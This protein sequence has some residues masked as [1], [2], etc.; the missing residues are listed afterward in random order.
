MSGSR[1]SAERWYA[2]SACEAC[3][4]GR[5]CLSLWVRH[6]LRNPFDHSIM[7]LSVLVDEEQA[8]EFQLAC[9]VELC[10]QDRQETRFL[11]LEQVFLQQTSEGNPAKELP[12]GPRDHDRLADLG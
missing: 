9:L 12:F 5:Q 3:R 6:V 1:H 8:E 10:P 7:R 2:G 4:E 11:V